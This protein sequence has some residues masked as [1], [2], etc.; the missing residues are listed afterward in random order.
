MKELLA[1]KLRIKL[2]EPILIL[3]RPNKIY[4]SDFNVVSEEFPIEPV[5]I[6]IIF[7]K[8]ME[9]LKSETLKIISKNSLQRG[10]RLLICYPKKGNSKFSSYINRDDIFPT[11]DVDDDGYIQSSNY[12]FNQMVSLDEN[13]TIIEIKHE[14]K[15]SHKNKKSQSVDDYIQYIPEIIQDLS[16]EKEAL[17]FFKNL[18]YGYQKNWARYVYSAKEEETIQRR[19]NRMIEFLKQGIKSVNSIK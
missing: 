12:K 18:T 13:Y 17:Y 3:N 4:F 7:V 9:E 6:I 14:E 5:K 8:N 2:E 11:L 10:G 1:K 19:K 15:T 16:H